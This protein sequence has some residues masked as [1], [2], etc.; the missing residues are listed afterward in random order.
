[1]M[2]M[3]E[4]EHVGIAHDLGRRREAADHRAPFGIG[5]RDLDAEAD[6]DDAQ[7]RDDESLDPAEAEIL[8]PQ[9]QE[10]V[11]RSDQ[12]ADFERNAEQQIEPDRRADHLGKVGGADRDL[13]QHPERPRHRAG[14]RVAAGLRQIAAGA[15][16]EPRAQGLQQDRHQIGKQRN[17][18]QRVAEL[19]AAGERR[20]PVAGVHVADRDQIARPEERRELSPE[21]AGRLG[22][23][24]AEHLRERGPL[25]GAA[26]AARHNGL[27]RK[28]T[29]GRTNQHRRHHTVS[30][31]TTLM[32]LRIICNCIAVGTIAV[33]S[34]CSTP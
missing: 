11:E 27:R 12:H 33:A 13:R 30:V 29:L 4:I 25:A 14:K 6:R 7:Q 16:A 26:P 31:A 17:G 23:D 10:H 21:R 24:G 20:R 28:R 18:Q 2:P 15:D 8:H 3:R 22:G 19:R 32:L 1:M 5:H 9:D 34:G